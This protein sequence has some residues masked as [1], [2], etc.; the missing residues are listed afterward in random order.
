MYTRGRL[1]KKVDSL[2]EVKDSYFDHRLPN[3]ADVKYVFRIAQ[4]LTTYDL[5]V[6]EHLVKVLVCN[7]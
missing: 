4:G 2:V 3:I 6:C 7:V 5:I 1:Y